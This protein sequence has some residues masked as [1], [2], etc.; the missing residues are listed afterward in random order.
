MSIIRRL[1]HGATA[2]VLLLVL[3]VPPASAALKVERVVSPGGIEAWLI[4]DRML[5]LV[6]LSFAFRGGAA[7][8][9]VGK[10]GLAQLTAALLTEGAGDLK[11]PAFQAELEERSIGLSFQA[12]LDTVQVSLKSLNRDRDEAVRLMALALTRPRFDADAIERVRARSLTS[13]ARSA[14]DPGTIA[15]DAWMAAAFPDHP[16]GRPTR[17][18]PESV[19]S[20]G[21]ADFRAFVGQR[22]ARDNLLIGVVGDISA[23]ELGPLL[24]RALG[25]LPKTSTPATVADVTPA[26][27]GKTLVERKAVPQ[28]RIVFGAPGVKRNDPDY[29]AAYVMNYILGGGGFNS[30]LMTEVREKRGLTYGIYSYLS[31]LDH[32][33][34]LV[35]GSG[36][37]NARVGESL[38]VIRE[39][40]RQMRD[41]GPTDEELADA[42]TFLTGSFALR[43]DSTDRIAAMLVAIQLD[44]LGIDFLDRRNSFIERVSLDE[45]R[46]AAQRLLDPDRLLTVVVGEPAGVT[47][48]E[49]TTPAA[50]PGSGG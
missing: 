34:L 40:W 33:G 42:K 18:T 49:P 44:H 16:Y 47:D 32:T 23:A 30:R 22:L 24:D 38:T 46:R 26:G 41:Q 27:G 9:P 15:N 6:S 5:P 12:G 50:K 37:E 25:G 13:L 7:L 21:E 29:Y 19:K 20:L 35:G 2:L 14:E 4:Q 28:S 3:L 36:T 10:E 8:D 31:P 45:V 11:G 1:G 39:V 17:G 43:L 48:A